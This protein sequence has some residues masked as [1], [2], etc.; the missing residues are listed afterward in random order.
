MCVHVCTCAHWRPENIQCLGARVIDHCEHPS[1]ST[2]SQTQVLCLLLI[3]D[4]PLQPLRPYLLRQCLFL[5]LKFSGW[6]DSLTRELQGSTS[7]C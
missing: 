5:N 4:P 1:M 7:Q 2:G 6:L 3:V